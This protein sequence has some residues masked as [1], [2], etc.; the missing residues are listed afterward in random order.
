MEDAFR[1]KLEELSRS[2]EEQE[3]LQALEYE[4]RKQLAARG[5]PYALADNPIPGISEMPINMRKR[6]TT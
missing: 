6:R 4:E 1:G 5:V 2:A 3:R